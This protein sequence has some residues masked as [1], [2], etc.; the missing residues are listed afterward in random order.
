MTAHGTKKLVDAAP[1]LTVEEATRIVRKGL[2]LAARFEG[3]GLSWLPL[4][5][6]FAIDES[7]NL[8]LAETNGVHPLEYPSRFDVSPLL[9][10]LGS[11]LVPSPL[12]FAP[13]S[14]VRMLLP[15]GAAAKKNV[16]SVD[17][18]RK[19]IDAIDLKQPYSPSENAALSDI[20]L[21]RDHNDDVALCASG[22]AR[23]ASSWHALVVCDGVSSVAHAAGAAAVA[24]RASRDEIARGVATTSDPRSIVVQATRVADLA[25]RKLSAEM[26][27]VIGTTIVSALVRGDDLAVAWVGDSRAYWVTDRGEEQLTTDHAEERVLTS[28]LGM[29]DTGGRAAPV[30]PAVVTRTLGKKGALI[31]CSDGL[32][33]YF[34]TASAVAH[35][36]QSMQHAPKNSVLYARFLVNSA[37]A[38]GGADNVSVAVHLRGTTS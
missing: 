14:L 10:A 15:R 6:D 9:I 16:R 3:R 32:W 24:A 31:L 30:A 17:E 35:L 21:W 11:S 13:S 1:M 37:L 8:I 18:A 12:A 29:V 2:D 5:N 4:A 28:C 34:P 25:V 23:D 19:A 26:R 20:G 27:A 33:N 22:G 7:K 38:A 36:T